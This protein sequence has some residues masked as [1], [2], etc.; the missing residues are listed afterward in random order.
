MGALLPYQDASV[1][2]SPFTAIFEYAGI[3][4]AA[5]IMNFIVLTAVLSCANSGIYSASRMLYAIAQ[6]GKAP[7]V[8]AKTNSRGIPI[9]SVLLTSS[10]GGFAFLTNFMG[11]DK[12]YIILISASGLATVFSW[13]AISLSHVKFRG[14]LK[15]QNIDVETLQYK[16]R[17]YPIGP[18]MTATV[19]L[20]ALA[21]T[22]ID[23]NSRMTALFG[24][25]IF[26]LL[27]IVGKYLNAKKRLINLSDE[28]LR[29]QSNSNNAT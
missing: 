12:V 19:C 5:S 22:I 25:P 15:N 21:G 8:F 16:S 7:K 20:A 2:I 1:L 13:L 29:L 4:Y 27:F 28:E 18:I 26:I 11:A 17:W 9:A 10:L 14:W 6:E 23:E 24:I 3:P